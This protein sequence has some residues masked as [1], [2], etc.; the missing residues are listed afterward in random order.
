MCLYIKLSSTHLSQIG[1]Y[2]Q[3]FFFYRISFCLFIKS[4]GLAFSRSIIINISSAKSLQPTFPWYDK[5]QR[6]YVLFSFNCLMVMHLL[7]RNKFIFFGYMCIFKDKGIILLVLWGDELRSGVIKPN[8]EWRA[9]WYKAIWLCP[10]I[11]N[12]LIIFKDIFLI[13]YI[14]YIFQQFHD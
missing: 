4:W 8:K 7:D 9:L 11:F 5:I 12:Q 10:I 3:R 1:I 2:W 6:S 13:T 14:F